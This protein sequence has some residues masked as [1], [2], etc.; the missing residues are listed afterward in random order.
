M[1]LLI[2]DTSINIDFETIEFIKILGKENVAVYVCNKDKYLNEWFY[3]ILKNYD[4]YE[5]IQDQINY[6][7]VYVVQPGELEFTF[8]IPYF[9]NIYAN[10]YSFDIENNFDY[11]NYKYSKVKG[12]G[13][14]F[15]NDRKLN[16]FANWVGLNTYFLNR[17]VYT[18]KCNQNK[19][20]LTPKLNIGFIPSNKIL[21]NNFRNKIIEDLYSAFKSNWILHIPKSNSLNLGCSNI[22]V[23]DVLDEYKSIYE[24]S[25]LIINPDT[26]QTIGINYDRYCYEAMSMGCISIFPNFNNIGNDYIFDKVHYFKMDFVDV[27]TALNI[28]RYVDKRREKLERMSLASK[29]VIH[30]YF[31]VR[32]IVQQKIQIIKYNL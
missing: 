18:F 31:D 10:T 14:V 3:E 1:K 22:E 8:R 32:K 15:I 9:Y 7:A 12:A 13:A 17:P 28:L 19:K 30:K 21:E 4:E 16:K 23:Y 26:P 20:F 27:N 29:N 5:F 24:N 11:F 2:L 6:D 25:H